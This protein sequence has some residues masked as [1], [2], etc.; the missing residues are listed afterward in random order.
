M[1]ERDGEGEEKK[2][3]MQT[4]KRWEREKEK[5][6]ANFLY[7]IFWAR[8]GGRHRDAEKGFTFKCQLSRVYVY[9]SPLR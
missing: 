1:G 7:V 4:K 8:Q 2:T 5:E 9:V 3:R 6:P